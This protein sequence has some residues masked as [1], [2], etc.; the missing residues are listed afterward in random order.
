[1]N[2]HIIKQ[3]IDWNGI[4]VEVS[5]EPSWLSWPAGRYS[6]GHLQLCS[7]APERAPLPVTETGYRSLFV[8]PA[9]GLD[10]GGP[11]AFARAWLDQEALSPSWI[12]AQTEARQ[13]ALF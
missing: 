4:T 12:A 10:E 7:L 8:D 5:W 13:L 11:L 2:T 9:L 3:R 1:M 6:V